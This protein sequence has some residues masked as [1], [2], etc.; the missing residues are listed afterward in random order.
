MEN[1]DLYAKKIW[2]YMLMNQK[3]EK[4]DI[5]FALGSN[6]ILTA[7][8]AAELYY[9]GFAPYIICSGGFGK[10]T[11]FSKPEAEVFAD[12]LYKKG[13]PK[14]K[15][16]VENKATNTGENILFSKQ[17]L[18]EKGITVHK[19]L[20]VQ[21]P[22]MERRTFATLSKQWPEVIFQVTSSNISFEEYMR[23]DDFKKKSI[24]V[25]VGDL[26]RIR[27]YPKLGFQIKQEIP[28]EVWDAGQGLLSLG[29]NKYDLK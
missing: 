7:E 12:I 17:L 4:A 15:V 29:Y 16:F 2:N 3:L 26:L 14:E 22:Y 11:K 5:I 25:L 23:D 21:K 1:I 20:A 27:E 6:S 24:H 8:R 13:I 10:D 28:D 19:V 18:A 9:L